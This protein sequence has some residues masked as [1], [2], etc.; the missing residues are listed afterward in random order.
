M[1]EQEP[2]RF[3]M[4]ALGAARCPRLA[5]RTGVIVSSGNGTHHISAVRVLFDGF[6]S[7]VTL[8]RSYVEIETSEQA[9]GH[10]ETIGDR[11]PAAG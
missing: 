5:D 10:P 7:P 1:T 2:L 6:K 9:T 8:H 11:L 4:S 3:R